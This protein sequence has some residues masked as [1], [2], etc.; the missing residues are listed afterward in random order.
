[1]EKRIGHFAYESAQG[2][3]RTYRLTCSK[4]AEFQRFSVRTSGLDERDEKFLIQRAHKNGWSVTSTRVQCPQHFKS[5]KAYHAET[6]KEEGMT[7]RQET[8]KPDKPSNGAKPTEAKMVNGVHVEIVDVVRIIGH[9]EPHYIKGRGYESGWDDQRVAGELGLSAQSV[10][11]T[12]K[13]KYP[14]DLDP[15]E[16]RAF[17]EEARMMHG[18]L[19]KIS[20][21]TMDA[22]NRIEAKLVGVLE[23]MS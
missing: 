11:Q 6:K 16:M 17:L 23:R 2:A 20:E 7:T 15:Q 19:M 5:S 9:I 22:A 4:C 21:Q 18:N 10:E 13:A 1:M 3:V 12:R 14:G 8:T